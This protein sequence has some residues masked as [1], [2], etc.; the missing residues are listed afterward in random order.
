MTNHSIQLKIRALLVLFIMPLF[1]VACGSSGSNVPNNSVQPA[2]FQNP[3]YQPQ[4]YA[5]Q[6]ARQDGYYYSQPYYQ[7]GYQYQQQ[8]SSRH[9]SN[10]YAIAPQNQ[11]PYYD[12]DQY[13]V[14]PTSYGS[15]RDNAIP[16][17]SNQKF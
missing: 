7:G 11:Y 12:G 10:P 5:P 8:P 3:R 14:P 17:I 4:Q 6:P 13:Y 2:S 9:Y 15:S 1:C 16:N